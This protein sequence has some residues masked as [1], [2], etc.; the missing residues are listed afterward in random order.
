M[1]VRAGLWY[2]LPMSRVRAT[3]AVLCVVGFAGKLGVSPPVLL[4]AAR[5]DPA[6]LT[7]PD[8]VLLHSE[9][10]RLWDEAARLTG[11]PDFGMHLAE[12][13]FRV[14]QE[15]FD[16]LAF[17]ARSCATLG[18]NYRTM[19]RYLRLVHDGIYLELKEEGELARLVHGHRR[20]PAEPPRQPVEGQLTLALLQGRG[21]IG[22]EFVPR[23]VRFRHARPG[24][25]SEH[26][27]IFGA[28]VHFSC[29]RNELVLERALLERPQPHAE[30]RLLAVLERQ[31]E[32]FLSQLPDEQRF[33]DVVRRG[34]MEELPDRQP[35]VTTIAAKL[36][37]SPRSLQRRL[38]SE[39]ARFGDLLSELRRDV[40]LRYLREQR[41]SIGEVG[42][43]LGFLDG[44]SFHRAF[45]RW[46][47]STPGEYRRAAQASNGRPG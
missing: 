26:E 13:L 36:R 21:A 35:S 9:E 44:A 15:Q 5:L 40:A 16:V 11:D 27:R 4:A 46:T 39:G 10:L 30:A 43:L 32:G 8:V 23:E 24:R 2:R 42:F 17:A 37:M 22:E 3:K 6:L 33:R 45:R 19:G 20:E 29:P 34:M 31:L 28:P 1:K 12:W 47:G 7:G 14:P 25:V 38:E 18:E 41:M